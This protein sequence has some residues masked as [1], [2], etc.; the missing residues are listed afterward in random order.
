LII[1]SSDGRSYQ[2]NWFEFDKTDRY[3]S[4]LSKFFLQ[5]N[6]P[7][8]GDIVLFHCFN[9]TRKVTHTG[10]YWMDK[11]F[12]HA[13]SNKNVETA[14]LNSRYWGSKYAGAMCYRGFMS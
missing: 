11:A 14:S 10:I 6:E 2:S 4:T 8:A 9:R 7:Q 1:P 13:R 3:M 5:V 12:F